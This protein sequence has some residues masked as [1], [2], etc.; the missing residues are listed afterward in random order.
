MKL[1]FRCAALAA[2]LS[3]AGLAAAQTLRIASPGDTISLDPHAAVNES[4][5]Y[6]LTSNVYEPLVGR[7]KDLSLAP[8]L[9][10]GW[11]QTAPTVWQFALRA[12]VKFQDGAPLAADDVVFSIERAARAGLLPGV[13]GARAVVGRT[14]DIETRQPQPLLPD[15]LT[16]IGILPRAW[17]QSHDPAREANGT[18]PYAV[19][20]RVPGS[21]TVFERFA[22]YWGSVEGNV[23]RVVFTP[24]PD[25]AARVAGLLKDG[26]DL[27]EP[28]PVADAAKVKASGEARVV[29]GPELRTIFLGMDQWRDELPN[30]SVK[31]RNP[32]KDVRVRQAFYQAIDIEAITKKVQQGAAR[33]AALIVGPGINGWTAAL[34]KRLAFDAKAAK[35]LLAEAGYP[36]G[37]ALTLNCPSDRYVNDA[38]VCRAIGEQLGRIGVR[39]QV[40][41]ESKQTYFPRLLRRDTGFYLLG[42][43]PG[44]YDAAAALEALAQCR[45]EG[46]DAGGYNV[47]GYCNPA[48][49]ALLER[50]G[51]ETDRARRNQLLGEALALHARD[52]GHIPLYQ[53]SLSWGVANDAQVVQLPDNRFVF[54]WMKK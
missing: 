16:E 18:G 31:G 21:R 23:Q 4:V 48:L 54:K 2:A 30:A 1:V 36:E 3:T 27:V 25:A 7:N 9:S 42:W 11:R 12:G 34:D 8:L 39:V 38:A 47:G 37:F 20:E 50:L 43:T 52:V 24:Q 28:V 45:T 53:Q 14:V 10:T 15:A 41:V 13:A 51:R 35:A 32:F 5:Q 22:G 40:A 49:D 26:F 6:S 29:T 44:T 33:P 19:R 46:A 17:A